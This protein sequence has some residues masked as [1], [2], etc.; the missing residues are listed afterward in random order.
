MF[1]KGDGDSDRQKANSK[2]NTV[3]LYPYILTV[4]KAALYNIW[5]VFILL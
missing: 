5:P 4:D 1:L 3:N 2:G